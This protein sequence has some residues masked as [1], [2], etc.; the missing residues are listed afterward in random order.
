MLEAFARYL[1]DHVPQPSSRRAYL[2][3][4]RHLLPQLPPVA[5]WTAVSLQTALNAHARQ[6]RP[7][8]HRRRVAA[9]RHFCRALGRADLAG[10]IRIHAPRAS[11]PPAATAVIGDADAERLVAAAAAGPAGERD[12]LLM[13]LMVYG[14]LKPGEIQRL[15]CGDLDLEIPCLRVGGPA[16]RV[17][18]L[19]ADLAAAFR[20]YT[21][22]RPA[23][24]PLFVSSRQE[25]L[26]S[27][28]ID[29][30]LR[31]IAAAAGVSGVTSGALRASAARRLSQHGA[32]L[33]SIQR[34]LGLRSSA[35][36]A[37]Y[38]DQTGV[39]TLNPF[40]LPAAAPAADPPAPS[41]S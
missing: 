27:V 34:F 26:S 14:G 32:D 15:C 5:E 1:E 11:Q 28:G 38:L 2:K 35:A 16:G 23:A 4:I 17:L 9:L 21:A 7:S 18:P 13:T 6:V 40:A 33:A 37:R 22:D 3:D 8:T 29:W 41:A 12:R 25:A 30:I 19:T 31:R 20:T 24:A 10:A 36:A 39:R